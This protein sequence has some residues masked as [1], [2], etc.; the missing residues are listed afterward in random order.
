MYVVYNAVIMAAGTSSRFA[1]LSYEKPKALISVKGEILIERQIRQ[2]KEAGICDIYVVV[3]YKAEMFIYL[4]EKFGV[5]IVY[6][7]NYLKRNNNSSIYVVKDILKN[8]YVCSA[9]NYFSI[10]P[11]E[12]KVED[13]YYSAVHADGATKEWCMEYDEEGTICK[14]Q[15]GGENAWYMLGHTFWNETFSSKFVE[16]LNNEYDHPETADMLWENIFINHLDELKMKIRK[17]ENSMIF[18]FDTLDELREFDNSYVDDT[19]SVILKNVAKQ[20][21]CQEKDITE[22][23]AYK[24]ESNEAAGFMFTYNGIRFSYSYKGK[25]VEEK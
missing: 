2:L 11:F 12:K 7:P 8:T 15:I 25:K 14:V 18:E 17:Y 13:S 20:L 19:R 6:N 24:D 10:N 21:K 4:E 1:P 9:D 22:V 23:V 16:I 3:G 5:H